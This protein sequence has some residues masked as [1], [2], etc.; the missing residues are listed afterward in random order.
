MEYYFSK[1]HYPDYELYI[2]PL[3]SSLDQQYN[4]LTLDN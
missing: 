2:L 1:F 3:N 4:P